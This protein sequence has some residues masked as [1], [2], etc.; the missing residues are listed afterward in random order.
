MESIRVL[1]ADDHTLFRDGLKALLMSV[2]DIEPVDETATGQATIE[3]AIKTQPDVILMDIQMPDVNGIEATRRILRGSPHIGVI[4]LTMFEDDESVFAAMR[5]GARGYV[6]KGADQAVML[7]AIR[8]VANG[9]SLFS[10]EIAKR[11]MHFFSNLPPQA[12]D[13]IF[14]EL[15]DREREILT[16]IANGDT[17]A[18]IADRLVISLKTVRNH[19]SNIFNKL[20]VADRTQAALRAR[21]AG[22]GDKSEM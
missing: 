15:T 12:P 8:S 18:D 1:I 19:V 10:P 14:P 22:L 20:Q 21:Q 11:L 17:N 5:A 9:E 16:L 13:E 6:L 3:A 7:R 2:P 4:M